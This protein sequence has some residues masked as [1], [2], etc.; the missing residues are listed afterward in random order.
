MFR[1][2]KFLYEVTLND[3]L[4]EEIKC[5]KPKASLLEILNT[6]VVFEVSV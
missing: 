5:E 6:S 3:D 2:F 1:C 4:R